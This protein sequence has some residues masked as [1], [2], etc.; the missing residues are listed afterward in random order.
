MC[1]DKD[2]DRHRTKSIPLRLETKHKE[3]LA[4]IRR[5]HDANE[6]DAIRLAIEWL[7]EKERKEEEELRH[8]G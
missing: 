7:D 8:T 4:R 2:M 3:A 1:Y 5:R 6:S